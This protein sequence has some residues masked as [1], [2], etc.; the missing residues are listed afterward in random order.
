[1]GE[2]GATATIPGKTARRASLAAETQRLVQIDL[3]DLRSREYFDKQASKEPQFR[4]HS[5]DREAPRAMDFR[6]PALV[7]LDCVAQTNSSAPINVS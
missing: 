6:Y 3:M 1:M 4:R 2:T 5:I 7:G